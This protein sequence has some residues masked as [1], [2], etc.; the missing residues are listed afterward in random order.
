MRSPCLPSPFARPRVLVPALALLLLAL[1][2][3]AVPACGPAAG[4]GGG[5]GIPGPVGEAD[6]GRIE[7]PEGGAVRPG[8]SIP[9]E[10]VERGLP[11]GP[12]PPPSGDPEVRA[13]VE[14]EPG[15]P[16]GAWTEA[17]LASMSLRQKVGQMIMPWVLGD[18]SPE[19]SAGHE[20]MV[21]LVRNQ[22]IG[23]IIVSVG[24]P[25]DV[26][27]KVNAFQ[28][29]A[30][31]PL[32]VA[33]DLETGAGFRMR[34]AVYLPGLHDLG[35]ATNF[36]AL[37]AVGATGDRVLAYEM[38]RITAQEARAVGVHLP[39]A[40]VLDVNSNP[41]NPIINT[42][43]FGE[44]PAQV[45][46]LGACFVRGV[47]DHGG[48][49]TG[50]H[51]P[52]HGDTETDSHLAL[53][54][55][56]TG[57]ARLDRVELPPFRAA[58]QAGMGAVMTAHIALPEI[59]E[60]PRLP[61]TL[62]RRVMTGLLRG[63]LGFEGLIFTDAMDMN[64]IDRLFGREEAAVRAVLAGVDVLLMPPDPEAAIRGVMNA[65]LSGRIPESRI[66]DS[67][68]RILL[69]K[70]GLGLHHGA[71]VDLDAVHRTVGIPAH[72]A[73][74]R[75]VAERSL[76]LLRNERGILPLRGTSTASVLSVTFRRTHDL[77]A[78]R[79]FD[80]RL[81]RTY[82]R[83]QSTLLTRDTPAEELTRLQARARTMDLV[84]VSLHV[85]AVSSAGSVAI[86]DEVAR[87]I[88]ELARARIPHVVVSFGNPYLLR[89]F[90]DVQAYLLA[91]SGS[92]ASQQAAARALFGEIPVQGRTPTRIPPGFEIGAGLQLPGA[93]VASATRS[94]RAF[95]GEGCAF[96]V[97]VEEDGGG[98]SRP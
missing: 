64:A 3:L 55:I 86:P 20:R 58:I 21:R 62:S 28:A 97:P 40:P 94:G 37:M 5:A 12:V 83:L 93:W 34:G 85:T 74:A 41:D 96:P 44:D 32:L 70:E 71:R 45:A 16:L 90:P 61:A 81:R 49:A 66:D 19:G 59:A 1:L 98:A 13:P 53:P 9:T 18:F 8:D 25:L 80:A 56:R 91:W 89:E 38:G 29:E 88:Q 6:P 60:E 7:A 54:I 68:R 14:P 31:V 57:Q 82:P 67:A 26:A 43:A 65:V 87:F 10:W 23:G 48:I 2:L 33:A 77:M 84:V 42:R 50:K 73:V 78:G 76:T 69:A 11:P 15:A 4:P 27:S 75:E 30:R 95:S 51:F 52:G 39:F 35:G 47:Q 63:T 36:P 46:D 79:A 24:T 72:T 22:E 92:E 17:T